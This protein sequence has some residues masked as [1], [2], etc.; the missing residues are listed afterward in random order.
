MTRRFRVPPGLP[1]SL[2]GIIL[3]IIFKILPHTENPRGAQSWFSP[4]PLR[5]NE[6]AVNVAE[7]RPY[8]FRTGSV[9]T[10][11]LASA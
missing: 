2:Y 10:R 8:T 3:I 6:P 9:S 5:E 4:F 11:A 1:L 7:A